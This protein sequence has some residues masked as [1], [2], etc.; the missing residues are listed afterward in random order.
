[1]ELSLGDIKLFEKNFKKHPEFKVSA[2]A[3]TGN[4]FK[5]IVI[6]NKFVNNFS[7]V[8]K[9]VIEIDVKTSNQNSSGRCWMFAYLNIIRLNMI[10]RWLPLSFELSQTFFFQKLENYFYI[11][12]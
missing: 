3:L 7:E 11:L 2:N 6:N 5:N 8:F 12:P 10:K 4:N 9:K 1:M